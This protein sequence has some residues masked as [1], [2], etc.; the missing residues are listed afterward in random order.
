MVPRSP[1]VAPQMSAA[2][3]GSTVSHALQPVIRPKRRQSSAHCGC[4]LIRSEKLSMEVCRTNA[5]TAALGWVQS[6]CQCSLLDW[7]LRIL[8]RQSVHA[9]DSSAQGGK[10][11]MAPFTV[12]QR[13]AEVFAGSTDAAGATWDS[14]R[15]ENIPAEMIRDEPIAMKGSEG[16]PAC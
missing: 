14:G 15:N 9:N 13:M 3:N 4:C 16:L 12:S 8:A 6:R 1:G 10:T 11:C 5:H 2:C 7:A